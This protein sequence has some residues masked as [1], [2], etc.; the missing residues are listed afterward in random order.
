MAEKLRAASVSIIANVFL[1]AIKLAVALMTNSIGVIAE[2]L[3]SLFDLVASVFAYLGIQ[4][5]EQPPDRT[6]LYGHERFENMSALV[7]T[8]LLVITSVLIIFE[9]WDRIQHPVALG[10]TEL[11]IAVIAL[12]I[13]IDYLVAKFLHKASDKHGS[14]A[15][16][17]DAYHFSTDLLTSVAVVIGLIGVRMGFTIADSLAAVLV[18]L[19]ML[20]ISFK[21]GTESVSVLLDASP[22]EE[23]MGRIAMDVS[24]TRGVRGYHSLRARRSGSKYFIDVSVHLD[25]S[26][27]LKKA[28]AIAQ[29]LER[30]LKR[31][32]PE[33]A[34][35]VVHEEPTD[36]HD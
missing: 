21:I 6:H 11:G 27:S 9:A 5:A 17:A 8:L 24:K 25:S 22:P 34:D 33:V 31:D 4:K 36:E 19:A 3:H 12:S 28:H 29:A 16:Q 30:K 26:Y 1:I 2:V 32:F 18:A 10:M 35:V 23:L 20:F 7:Q 13:V 14:S 15:L